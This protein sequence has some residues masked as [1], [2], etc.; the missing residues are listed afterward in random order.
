MKNIIIVMILLVVL[1]FVVYDFYLYERYG[2]KCYGCGKRMKELKSFQEQCS[3]C[4]IKDRAREKARL[5]RILE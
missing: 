3:E 5:L 1:F 2:Q 4:L